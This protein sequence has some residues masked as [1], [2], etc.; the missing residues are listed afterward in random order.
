MNKLLTIISIFI[1][2]FNAVSQDTLY[3]LT[4]NKTIRSAH[5]KRIASNY[6]KKLTNNKAAALSLPFFDDFAQ[7]WH[8]PKGT[9]WED[10]NVFINSNYPINPV[11]YGVATFDGLDS[12]GYPYDFVDSESHGI[13]DHLT[14]LPI[15]LSSITDSVFIS[16]Y[17]QPQGN[18][19]KP[20]TKDSIRLEFF[21]PVDSTWNLAWSKAGTT[22]HPFKQVMIPVDT[23]Y[24]KNNFKFRFLNY[25]SLAAN[26]DHWNIDHVYLNDNRN[27]ADT[28]L[29]DFAIVSHHHNMLQNFTQMPWDHYMVDSTLN[30]AKNMP[31][32]YRN[33]SNTLGT[34]KYFY[35]V[36]DNNGAGSVI[37]YYLPGEKDV[38]PYTILTEPQAVFDT[39]PVFIHDFYFPPD[40][41][42]QT[43]VFQIKNY[44]N[45]ITGDNNQANDTIYNYQVFGNEY[46]Y[47]D[48]SAENGYGVQGIDENLA[49]EFDIKKTDTLTS[50]KIYFNPIKYNYSSESF[51][52]TVWSSIGSS[53][54]I[55]YQ[56]TA[57]YQPIYSNTNEFL[58]YTLDVPL[59]LTAGTY[60]FG[61]EKITNSKLNVGWDVNTNNQSKVHFTIGGLWQTASYPGS[62][63]IHPVFGT[64]PDPVVTIEENEI[65]TKD[66]F[67]V[68]P[69]PAKNVLFF[70]IN[71]NL[72]YQ[73]D[74]MDV[75][76]KSIIQSQS[77]L[78]NKIDISALSQGIYLVRFINKETQQ[79]VTKKVIIS[80]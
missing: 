16:F 70:K 76:G 51:K 26:A 4:T 46:A 24:H 31:V 21:H 48:G 61:W 19:N 68:Y 80:K 74:I 64:A 10:I 78:T 28:A 62:L 35:K 55:I 44:F 2:S 22:N 67:V 3:D 5:Q 50:I 65:I 52:L 1:F 36:I 12:T 59:V 30:M 42:K 54:T 34:V 9:L 23:A 77:N 79:I 63:M 39:T 38:N 66:D 56:Q 11:S 72:S 49:H 57:Y 60:Y 17:Y 43:A 15:N 18:G 33:N 8:Y 25:A 53:E 13:A 14:S 73:I 32:Q 27:H 58:K 71:N 20:E 69:N 40:L 7:D 29:F 45:P 6:S 47:D 75:F 41:S 37:D